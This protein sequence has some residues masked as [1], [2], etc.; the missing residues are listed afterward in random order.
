MRGRPR[1]F[2]LDEAIDTA[3]GL[4]WRNGYEGTS[5]RTLTRA[6]GIQQPSFYA[7]FGSKERLFEEVFRRGIVEQ[8]ARI[9][10]ACGEPHVRAVVLEVL[11]YYSGIRMNP[12]DCP[13]TRTPLPCPVD[14][15]VRANLGALREVLH[16]RLRDRF[17]E[18]RDAGDIPLSAEPG[19]FALLLLTVA[20]GLAVQGQLGATNQDQL[21]TIAMALRVWPVAG[22]GS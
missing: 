15:R 9:E 8:S 7:A 5:V 22:E 13:T 18:A 21:R 11:H 17:T 3:T 12:R 19:V 1:G 10:A 4:F 20:W 2:D 6:M 16:S 14:V